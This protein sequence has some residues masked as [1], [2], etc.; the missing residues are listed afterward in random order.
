[1]GKKPANRSTKFIPSWQVPYQQGILK[2]IGYDAKNKLINS[3]T[4][5]SASNPVN[6]KLTADRNIIK[7]NNQDLCYIT[8]EL[9]DSKDNLN[10]LAENLVTFEIDGPGTF[11]GV[12]N[13][14]PRSLESCQVPERKA[15]QGKCLGNNCKRDERWFNKPQC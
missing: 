11:I 14:N 12:G 3:A 4:L 1:M 8:V 9:L 2:A 10:P 7:A 5:A 13:G 6:I 15:W